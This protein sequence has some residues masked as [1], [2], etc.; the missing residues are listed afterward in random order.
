MILLLRQLKKSQKNKESMKDNF[1]K[2]I[3]KQRELGCYMALIINKPVSE[4]E[5][6]IKKNN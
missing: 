4:K 3:N 2:I 1:N 5:F 6:G